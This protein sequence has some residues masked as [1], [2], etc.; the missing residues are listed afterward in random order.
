M[1]SVLEHFDIVYSDFGQFLNQ[2]LFIFCFL[3]FVFCII[4][5]LNI[6]SFKLVG[7]VVKY[8]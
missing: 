2:V 3:F 1:L 6:M 4:F 7:M 5:S 8:F